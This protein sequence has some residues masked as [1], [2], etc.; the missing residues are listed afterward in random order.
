MGRVQVGV[1]A[2]ITK[3]GKFLIGKRK[4]DHGNGTWGLVGGHLEF[5]ESFEGCVIREAKEEAGIAVADLDVIEV[6]NDIFPEKHY[7]TVFLIGSASDEP[8][9]MEPDKF[10]RWEWRDWD[11]MPEP[12]FLPFKTLVESGFRPAGL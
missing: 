4:S 12:L 6:T 3:D 5:Q 7:I 9:L 2:I 11:D 8:R 10:E 1:A